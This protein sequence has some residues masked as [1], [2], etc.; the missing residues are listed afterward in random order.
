M[1]NVTINEFVFRD[2]LGA[3]SKLEDIKVLLRE[4]M[5]RM[6]KQ[7]LVEELVDITYSNRYREEALDNAG[8]E[9]D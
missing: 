5:Y 4:P 9:M 1:K 3:K 6:T 7:R 2:L 8:C